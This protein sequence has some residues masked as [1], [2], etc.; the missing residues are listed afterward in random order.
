M[1]SDF[2]ETTYERA[3]RRAAARHDVVLIEIQ[4]PHESSLPETGPVLLRDAETG[5]LAVVNPSGSGFGGAS[6]RSGA[7]AHQQ[8]RASE[9]D[10]LRRT[11]AKLGVDLLSLSTDRAYLPSLVAFFAERERRQ[12]G[13]ILRTARPE[14]SAR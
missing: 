6:G 12:G 13:A 5:R 10:A 11:A 7:L 14:G 3:V 2:V 4:D 9:R 1:I 8:R